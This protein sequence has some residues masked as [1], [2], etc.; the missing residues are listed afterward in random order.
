M[1]TV[2]YGDCSPITLPGKVVAVLTMVGGVLV[3]ALPMT[4]LGSN[5]TKVT[6]MYEEDINRFSQE[7]YDND[8]Q[9]DET[10]L[11][12]W[13]RTKRR[14]GVLRKDV[15]TTI[16]TLFEK[17]DPDQNGYIDFASFHKM[18]ADGTP[19]P[20]HFIIESHPL[21][22]IVCM[23]PDVIVCHLIPPRLILIV[24]L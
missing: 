19:A 8:G 9:L 10:E 6:E 23:L 15:D 20:V 12:D 13:L 17:Y 18:Q 21:I 22:R 3:L 7:D 4:V 24:C 14:E 5:F 16:P 11:R 1:S 2:G